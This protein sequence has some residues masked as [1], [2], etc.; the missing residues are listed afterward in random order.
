MLSNAIKNG[1]DKCK[2]K[3]IGYVTKNGSWNNGL[4]L[5]FNVSSVYSKYDRSTV[6]DFAIPTDMYAYSIRGDIVTNAINGIT[7]SYVAS[8]GILTL[9]FSHTQSGDS[10]KHG[11]S[12]KLPII[13]LDRFNVGGVISQLVTYLA[14]ILRK[15]VLA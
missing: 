13:I 9:K 2:L 14:N 1:N 7:K 11:N 6:D 3:T 10:N 5:K 12:F 15:E 8:T 4:T